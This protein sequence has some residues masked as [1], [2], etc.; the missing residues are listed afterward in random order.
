MLSAELDIPKR[1]M[2][3]KTTA[4]TEPDPIRQQE[5]TTNVTCPLQFRKIKTSKE[6]IIKKVIDRSFKFDHFNCLN[7][8]AQFSKACLTVDSMTQ[9]LGLAKQVFIYIRALHIYVGFY[10]MSVIIHKPATSHI[11]FEFQSWTGG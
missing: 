11:P 2:R 8:R 5:E 9:F 10:S 3:K 6:I 4:K 1:I 7:P